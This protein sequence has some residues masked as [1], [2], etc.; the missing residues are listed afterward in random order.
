[1]RTA[2]I[3]WLI[4]AGCASLPG[5]G[6]GP[7]HWGA[8]WEAVPE[9]PMWQITAPG[10]PGTVILL[11]SVHSLEPNQQ[12]LD[13]AVWDELGRA[14]ALYLERVGTE[15]A[16]KTEPGGWPEELR[17]EVAPV[18]ESVGLTWEQL[19]SHSLMVGIT[20]LSRQCKRSA[21]VIDEAG[22][23]VNLMN[24]ARRRGISLYSLEPQRIQSFDRESLLSDLRI[25]TALCRERR[26]SSPFPIEMVKAAFVPPG[27]HEQMAERIAALLE[28]RRRTMVVVG[29]LHLDPRLGLPELLGEHGLSIEPLAPSGTRR[30][31][32]RYTASI[33]PFSVDFDQPPQTVSATVGAALV[34]VHKLE[35][36][37]YILFF[38]WLPPQ[39]RSIEL[40]RSIHILEE[41]GYEKQHVAAERSGELGFLRT[42]WRDPKTGQ[43]LIADAVEMHDGLLVTGAYFVGVHLG[44]HDAVDKDLD[45]LTAT[46]RLVLSAPAKASEKGER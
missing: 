28:E 4:A 8:G 25:T 29:N 39:E 12:A 30:A 17:E 15:E 9:G 34:D 5:T 14:D 11:G 21:G 46:A 31:P 37:D 24:E 33:G 13:E 10:R 32:E 2:N 23:D 36:S 41:S 22:V 7:S 18:A 43:T 20:L 19:S 3:A 38:V 40:G 27:R 26:R 16:P 1:M 6:S 45:R 44:D 42:R 35:R